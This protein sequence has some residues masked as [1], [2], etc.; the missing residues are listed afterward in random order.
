MISLNTL[1]TT[2]THLM[3]IILNS[4]QN[5]FLR[6][7]DCF[8]YLGAEFQHVSS[9]NVLEA[10]WRGTVPTTLYHGCV[11]PGET[12]PLLLLEPRDAATLLNAVNKQ[13][14]ALLSPE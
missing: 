14:F 12:V 5:G 6:K 13:L 4:T 1:N 10:G 11:F 7:S 2:H 8:Q 3:I 9:H